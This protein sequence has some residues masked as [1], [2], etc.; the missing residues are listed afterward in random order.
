MVHGRYGEFKISVDGQIIIDGGALTFLGLM[1]SGNEIVHA[2]R[3]ILG[4]SQ[5]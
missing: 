4:K 3:S 2:V 1:P 5:L